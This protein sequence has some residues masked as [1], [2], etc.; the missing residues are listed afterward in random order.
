MGEGID[1]H[2]PLGTHIPGDYVYIEN[3][4]FTHEMHIH[5]V[6]AVFTNQESPDA[7]IILTG[8]PEQVQETSRGEDGQITFYSNVLL[9]AEIP[10]GIPPVIRT[11][12][13]YAALASRILSSS[14][15]VGVL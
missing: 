5:Q 4:D 6:L 9:N 13:P 1:L 15:S 8:E 11:R 7:R 10:V 2:Q 3:F 14:K 12:L